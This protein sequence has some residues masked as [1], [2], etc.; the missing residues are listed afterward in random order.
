MPTP[1]ARK[2][3]AFPPRPPA[4]RYREQY[5]VIV[6]CQD[7]RHHE[8]VYQRCKRAGLKCR[9]RVPAGPITPGTCPPACVPCSV[10]SG[11]LRTVAPDAKPRRSE[12]RVMRRSGVRSNRLRAPVDCRTL[13]AIAASEQMSNARKPL[14]FNH[15]RKIS[16]APEQMAKAP[17]RPF[18]C[19][20][21]FSP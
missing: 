7:A 16:A 17:K 13:A 2:Q 1:K 10:P 9:A 18:G 14:Q 4:G 19:H 21:R 15:L 20:M 3:R 6:I 8:R 11:A 5:G 12:P